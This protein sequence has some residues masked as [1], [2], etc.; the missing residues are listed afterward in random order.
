MCVDQGRH[1]PTAMM[2]RDLS[3][4]GRYGLAAPLAPW[5]RGTPR[6]GWAGRSTPVLPRAQDSAHEQGAIEPP[7][8]GLRRFLQAHTA[9]PNPI[10]QPPLLL[11]P[12]LQPSSGSP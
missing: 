7:G 2:R 10:S 1:L 8:T 6:A 12:L 11:L 4:A 5:A 9:P 3:E